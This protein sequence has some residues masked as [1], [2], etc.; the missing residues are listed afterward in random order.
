MYHMHCLPAFP[1]K[2]CGHKSVIRVS[3]PR[4]HLVFVPVAQSSSCASHLGH[5]D[6]E[7]MQRGGEARRCPDVQ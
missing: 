7:V 4:M 5:S 2:S 3:I 1:F 6:K